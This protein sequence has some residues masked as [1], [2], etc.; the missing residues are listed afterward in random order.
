MGTKRVWGSSNNGR[1]LLT[2]W[3][4]WDTAYT[5]LYEGWY[6]P[7]ALVQHEGLKS[8]GWPGVTGI[9]CN[10]T[11]TGSPRRITEA[12]CRDLA[13]LGGAGWDVVTHSQSAGLNYGVPGTWTGVSLRANFALARAYMDSLGVQG[14]DIL[15]PSGGLYDESWLAALEYFKYIIWGNP[16]FSYNL[17]PHQDY[18]D[19]EW[20]GCADVHDWATV[21]QPTLDL[22]TNNPRKV[23]VCSTHRFIKPTAVTTTVD[24]DSAAGTA[25]LYV[26]DTMGLTSDDSV[27]VNQGGPREEVCEIT[28]TGIGIGYNLAANLTYTHTALQAD[29]VEV[30]IQGTQVSLARLDQLLL[31]VDTLDATISS[32]S[33]LCLLCGNR[34]RAGGVP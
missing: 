19:I 3:D 8:R 27:I 10:Y 33:Q 20:R 16:T 21:V 31:Y 25:F 11:A 30:S 22:V 6:D 29:V 17:W 1:I 24:Q 32:I 13:C 12:Q 9:C 18:Y 23:V 7:V 4:G 5:C 28:G 34:P 15:A 26:A 14:A 2:N